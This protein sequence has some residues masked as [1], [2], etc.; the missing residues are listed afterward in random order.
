MAIFPPVLSSSLQNTQ[1]SPGHFSLSC[2]CISIQSSLRFPFF[3]P[4]PIKFNPSSIKPALLQSPSL[5]LYK[6]LHVSLM[7]FPL[8]CAAHFSPRST[9]SPSISVPLLPSPFMALIH[10]FSFCLCKLHPITSVIFCC[11][12]LTIFVTF[13]EHF[14]LFMD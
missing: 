7:P 6:L 11:K 2:N 5:F 12:V 13:E 8:N 3:P 14:F 9:E 4:I 1:R 10:I